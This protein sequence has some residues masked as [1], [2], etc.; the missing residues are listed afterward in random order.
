M[1]PTRTKAALLLAAAATSALVAGCSSKQVDPASYGVTGTIVEKDHDLENC[2]GAHS[3]GA[4]GSEVE[5]ELASET[6]ILAGPT[7]SPK[8]PKTAPRATQ[9]T[10]PTTKAPVPT[11]KAPTTTKAPAPT[12]TAPRTSTTAPRVPAAVPDLTPTTP[13]TTV[14]KPSRKCSEWELD[15]LQADGT[16]VEID[17][18]KYI[19]DRYEVGRQFP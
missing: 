10:V 1:T 8:P 12:T 19:Y 5:I 11:T 18:E 17:V 2:R 6:R 4:S 7:S 14:K 13:R 16:A 15:I 9:A 3:L